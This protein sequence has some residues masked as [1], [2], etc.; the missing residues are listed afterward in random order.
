MYELNKFISHGVYERINEDK[1]KE[2]FERIAKVGHPK[3]LSFNEANSEFIISNKGRWHD[4]EMHVLES[5]GWAFLERG[6]QSND[7]DESFNNQQWTEWTGVHEN[8]MFFHAV[9][10]QFL[11][12]E[13]ETEGL[14]SVPQAVLK[15]TG[16]WFTHPGQFRVHAIEYTDCNEDFVVWDTAERL[17]Q[18]EISF[19]EWYQLYSHHNDKALFVV[20]FDDKLEMH[21]GEERT[22][23]CKQVI[24]ARDC[25]KG[26]KPILEGTCDERL[27]DLFEHGTYEGHGIGIVG[28]FQFKDLKHL[29][30]FLPTK[31]SIEK[32][33]FVL[34]NN[35]HK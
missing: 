25:F 20:P 11:V 22:Q 32:N 7:V 35:Y 16:K 17:P 19:D 1:V 33:N 10:I 14:Y 31:Q 27:T 6:Y 2:D 29:M 4:T 30:S 13:I 3:I 9:N 15:E 8:N 23:L 5:Y 24:E 34:Y 21:V 28:D 26:Q 12:H 18:P